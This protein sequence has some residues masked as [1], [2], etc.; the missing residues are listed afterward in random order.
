[1]EKWEY[2]AVTYLK[3]AGQTI[4]DNAEKMIG[5]YKH[6]TGDIDIH[7]T[8]RDGNLPEIEVTQRLLPD[9]FRDF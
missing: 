4:V 3:E 2:K 9:N 7:I 1:M 5:G 8:L 6:Q